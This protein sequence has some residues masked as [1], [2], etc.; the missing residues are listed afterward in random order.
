M[1]EQKGGKE[2]E[3]ERRDRNKDE[4]RNLFSLRH[5]HICILQKTS[6]SRN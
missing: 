5:L 2:R 6:T 1:K 3:D 4:K